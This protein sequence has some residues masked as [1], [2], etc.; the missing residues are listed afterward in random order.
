M[1]APVLHEKQSLGFFDVDLGVGLLDYG[2]GPMESYDIICSNEKCDP[3][4]AVELTALDMTMPRN[5]IHASYVF[6]NSGNHKDFMSPEKLK[7]SL[8]NALDLVPALAGRL[9]CD[10]GS[11]GMNFMKPKAPTRIL[12]N[13]KGAWFASTTMKTPFSDM[14]NNHL[15][16]AMIP[17]QFL[18]KSFLE[19]AKESREKEVDAPLLAIK[20]VYFDCGSVSLTVYINH[21]VADGRGMY[22]FVRM[23][24]QITQ[25]AT[26]NPLKESRHVVNT[27][28]KL[29]PKQAAQ[30]Q[31]RFLKHE[32][33]KPLMTDMQLCKLTIPN[34]HLKKIKEDINAKIA[35]A[36]IS[37]D[38]LF[39]CVHM[40]MLLRARK[41]KS[42]PSIA[43]LVS[44]RQYLGVDDSAFGNF[45]N[46]LLEGPFDSSA[47]VDDPLE[48]VALELRKCLVGY[49]KEKAIQ[50]N[51][52]F[53]SVETHAIPD[54]LNN[55]DC[56]RDVGCTSISSYDPT[57][58]SF[59][60]SPAFMLGACYYISGTLTI[61]HLLDGVFNGTVPIDVNMLDAYQND[62][63]AK[64]L[65]FTVTPMKKLIFE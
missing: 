31:A 44:I 42:N 39:Y 4:T 13:N 16:T 51:Q 33:F 59:Q 7:A 21:Q 17:S 12:F 58:I 34:A 40:R 61:N 46:M 43:R 25:G 53:I 27:I 65:G 3:N 52:E 24:G 48:K 56:S 14:R 2:N 11:S 47:L 41:E 30:V 62:K 63:E 6:E 20:A 60:D 29:D 38:D 54:Q 19:A 9:Q 10:D 45:V 50:A 18:F 15:K 36:Y 55:Y 49:T 1:S 37:S 8:V 57:K 22:E 32:P 23:W 35:P 5:W 26:P 28:P 64:E